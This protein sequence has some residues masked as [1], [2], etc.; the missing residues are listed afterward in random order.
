[1]NRFEF[2]DYLNANIDLAPTCV[3]DLV[4]TCQKKK[5]KKGNFLLQAGE[6]CKNTFFVEKG[7]LKQYS[8]DQKGKEHIL[9]FAPEGWFVSDRGSVYFNKESEYYIQALED[10]E[11]ALLDEQLLNELARKQ[12]SFLEFNNRLLHRHI[13]QLQHRITQLLGASAEARYLE[14]IK[15]YPDIMLRVPQTMVASY[16]GITPEGLSRVRKE[17]AKQHRS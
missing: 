2:T 3:Q 8:L 6:V 15:I 11:I 13:Q 4:N 16:L 17:M 9:Q 7:L 1:M 10:T 5:V 12:P 14:F